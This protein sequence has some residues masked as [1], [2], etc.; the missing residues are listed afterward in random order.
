M[1]LSN[2]V[3]ALQKAR[4]WATQSR[5]PARYYEHSE[6]GYN[7]RMSNVLA[8]IGRGQLRVLSDR[9]A[10]RKEVNT[11][12]RQAFADI[13]EI[14]FMPVADYGKPNYWLTVITLNQNSAIS[15]NQMMD[16]LEANN[17]ESRPV[18][19][20]MHLQP[21]FA[22]YPFFPHFTH[23]QQE[24]LAEYQTR[25]ASFWGGAPRSVSEDLFQRGVCLP[26]GSSMT[27][28]DQDRVIEV[29]R[30]LFQQEYIP[31]S[32]SVLEPYSENDIAEHS[33]LATSFAES[34]G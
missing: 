4:F 3:A 28:A 31:D 23:A 19:K 20:P 9:I 34:A 2:N 8:G 27:S 5:D 25:H 24:M 14:E 33:P 18:W 15:P 21:F 29:V 12:Y 16:A 32:V 17:I 11:R 22:K 7:Y 26:S 6:L 1:L 30:G 13:P 10:R